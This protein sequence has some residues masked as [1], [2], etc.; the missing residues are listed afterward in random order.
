[1][2]REKTCT[3]IKIS[4]LEKAAILL[5]MCFVVCTVGFF[6]W[7]NRN[8]DMTLVETAPSDWRQ[9]VA[10]PEE[11]APG[12]LRGEVLDLNTA[13]AEDLVRLPG[14][15]EKRAADIVAYRTEHGGFSQVEE[16]LE[17]SG[18]GQATFEG[19]RDYVTVGG[20]ITP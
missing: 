12:M 5:T 19:L 20:G 7:Q 1:M 8:R 2:Q 3:R 17:I 13:G 14:I 16:L 4:G 18:I 10:V 11:P 6:L 15:G 9:E